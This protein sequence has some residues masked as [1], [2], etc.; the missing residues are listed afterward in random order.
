[1]ESYIDIIADSQNGNSR[2]VGE[3]WDA[4][5]E[6]EKEGI[7]SCVEFYSRM[8]WIMDFTYAPQKKH[9]QWDLKFRDIF[10][11]PEKVEAKREPAANGYLDYPVSFATC[12]VEFEEKGEPSGLSLTESDFYWFDAG[13]G[14]HRAYFRVPTDQVRVWKE[15]KKANGSFMFPRTH[16]GMNNTSYGFKLPR[17]VMAE[18]RV[19]KTPLSWE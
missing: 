4:T 1:M 14:E 8:D 5:S 10:F 11:E 9:P 6:I 13:S 18:Y 12:F 15:M 17:D 2:F 16:G 7:Q 3:I 19:E